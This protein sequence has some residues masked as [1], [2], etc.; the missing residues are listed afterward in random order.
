MP[1]P[2]GPIRTI[3]GAGP[4]GASPTALLAVS[5]ADATVLEADFSSEVILSCNYS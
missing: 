1:A 3:R 4:A 5:T 2:G